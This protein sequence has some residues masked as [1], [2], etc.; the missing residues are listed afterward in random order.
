MATEI[1]RRWRRFCGIDVLRIHRLSLV[2][3]LILDEMGC[4]WF[5]SLVGDMPPGAGFEY[6]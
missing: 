2:T 5:E 3:P 6:D 4:C 1:G